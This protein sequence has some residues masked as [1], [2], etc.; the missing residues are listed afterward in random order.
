MRIR[1]TPAAADDLTEISEHLTILFPHYRQP[2][3]RKLY[4][5]V[6]SLKHPPH[7]V[8]PS[9]ETGTREVLFRPFPY[10]AAYRVRGEQIETLRIKQDRS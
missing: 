1:W 10:V 7:R 9:R 5:T 4:D 8:R 3:M 6:Q 2:T